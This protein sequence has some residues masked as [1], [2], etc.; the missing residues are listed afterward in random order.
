MVGLHRLVAADARL[1]D[2]GVDRALA[3]EV[4]VAELLLEVARDV[5][6]DLDELAADALALEL[7]VGDALRLLEEAGLGVDLDEVDAELALEDL[8][9]RLGLVEAHAAVVD[10]H[11]DELLADRLL[12]E[13][14]ADGRVDAARHREQHLPVADLLPDRLDLLGNVLLCVERPADSGE[15]LLLCLVHVLLTFP[16]VV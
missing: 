16:Y 1:D 8:L 2:V 12:Q 3:E 13:H 7:G 5:G 14:R 10:E 9:H 6:E 4:D 15:A 11:A